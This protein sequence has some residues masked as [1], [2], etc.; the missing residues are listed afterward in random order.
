[1]LLKKVLICSFHFMINLKRDAETLFQTTWMDF[2]QRDRNW[3]FT[4]TAFSTIN[5]RPS[6]FCRFLRRL[7]DLETENVLHGGIKKWKCLI[8]CKLVAELITFRHTRTL[9]SHLSH[10]YII[11]D[12][13]CCSPCLLSVSH[14]A[15]SYRLWISPKC[16]CTRIKNSQINEFCFILIIRLAKSDSA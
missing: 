4:L 13:C 2:W 7:I 15:P 14:T 6:W 10:D 1:M 8:C 16:L 3:A 12:V 11:L 5:H 9:R